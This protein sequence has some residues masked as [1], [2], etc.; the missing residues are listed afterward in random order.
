MNA[1]PICIC[2]RV[3][4]KALQSLLEASGQGSYRDDS[5]WLV[6]RERFLECAAAGQR[7]PVLF[8]VAGPSRFTHWGFIE[9]LDVTELHRASWETRCRFS[10]LAPV[11][12][13]FEPI[14][15]LFLN[16]G[17]ERRRREQLEG[18]H[19]HRYPLTDAELHPYAICETPAFILRT[20]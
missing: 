14:D 2:T 6:A 19:R 4:D 1:S 13:I 10:R 9:S 16:P 15:S 17:A 12:P 20:E 18:I 7:L 5:P 3:S 11:N 8:A